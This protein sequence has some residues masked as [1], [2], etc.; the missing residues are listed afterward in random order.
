MIKGDQPYSPCID[1]M[2]NI[3]SKPIQS[4]RA[5]SLLEVREF[6]SGN[7]YIPRHSEIPECSFVLEHLEIPQKR[8]LEFQNSSREFGTF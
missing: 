7:F 6:L 8:G 5:F 2:D 1:T 3:L 4:L